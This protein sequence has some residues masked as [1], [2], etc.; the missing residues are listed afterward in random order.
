MD[1]VCTGKSEWY[2]MLLGPTGVVHLNKEACPNVRPTLLTCELASRTYM[3]VRYLAY[4]KAYPPNPF[5]V[6]D[7]NLSPFPAPTIHVLWAPIVLLQ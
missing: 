6:L 7:S 3:C 5:Q 2:P 4:S 1:S